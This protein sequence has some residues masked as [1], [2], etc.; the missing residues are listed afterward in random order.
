MLRYVLQRLLAIV[1]ILIGV[2]VVTFCIAQVIPADPAVN[3]A[4]EFATNDQVAQIRKDTGLDRPLLIQY[5]L[6]VERLV[7]GDF[8]VSLFTQQPVSTELTNRFGATFDLA[9]AAMIL[10]L[11]I[12]IPAG[13]AGAVWRNSP[14]DHLAR[15]LALLGTAM[16]IFWLG[17]LLVR[18]FYTGLHW[19]PASGRY[20]LELT[21]PPTVTHSLLVDSIL[22]GDWKMLGSATSHLA[23]PALTLGIMGAGL[24]ARVM[25][26]SMLDVLGRE[27]VVTARAKGLTHRRIIGIHALRNAML[28][29]VT[30][31][32]IT[33]G[34]LLGGAVLTETIFSWPGLGL[35]AVESMNHLDFPAV[36]GVVI[37]ITVVYVLA[38]LI[39]DLMYGWLDPRVRRVPS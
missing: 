32:G 19:F 37:V 17:L 10:A 21:P 7:Q 12:G 27:F 20:A 4:G 29:T 36:M 39:V 2:T 16:P 25:R 30:V 5:G 1:A 33:Y 9:T 13:I 31:I 34:A 8:G 24:L 18:V 35:Y 14:I 23:L 22:A 26:A 38:N 11:L 28:P 15:L 3:L 6:Y